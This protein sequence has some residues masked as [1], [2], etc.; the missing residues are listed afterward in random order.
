METAKTSDLDQRFTAVTEDE[1]FEIS[2]YQGTPGDYLSKFVKRSYILGYKSIQHQITQ[3]GGAAPSQNEL[4]NFIGSVAWSRVAAGDYELTGTNLFT[5]NKTVI[6][7]MGS[8]DGTNGHVWQGIAKSGVGGAIVGFYS[9]YRVD[10][11]TIK[12]LVMD[13]TYTLVDLSS[14][15]GTAYIDL[16]EIRVYY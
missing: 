11:N 13:N 3:T 12:M 9:L 2:E 8:L 15:I 10:A 5:A 14:L 4:Q 7:G 1:L 16:P 6:C